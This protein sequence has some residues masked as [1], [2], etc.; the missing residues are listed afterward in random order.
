MTDLT[1]LFSI[2]KKTKKQLNPSTSYQFCIRYFGIF[3]CLLEGAICNNWPPV[4][5]ILKTNR[6]EACQP[7]KL[8]VQT[9]KLHVFTPNLQEERQTLKLSLWPNS[10]E[11]LQIHKDIFTPRKSSV[12]G[13]KI[14]LSSFH[15]NEWDST[16]NDESSFNILSLVLYR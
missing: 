13:F 1:F 2:K 4:E 3:C 16:S 10:V 9:G 14:P 11:E 8:A 7:N 5:F 6:R 12:F 15:R